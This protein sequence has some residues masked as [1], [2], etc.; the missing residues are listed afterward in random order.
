ML[1]KNGKEIRKSIFVQK[2]KNS[3]DLDNKFTLD[4]QNRFYIRE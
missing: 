1:E 4:I 3:F 2:I